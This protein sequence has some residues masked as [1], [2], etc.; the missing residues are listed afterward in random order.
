MQQNLLQATLVQ[1]AFERRGKH[2]SFR[3]FEG[4]L[5]ESHGKH[6]VLTVLCVP[7]LLVSSTAG[8]KSRI[9]LFPLLVE[10]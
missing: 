7:C 8:A 2:V 6:W 4:L 9:Q 10:S 3:R 5:H 1:A